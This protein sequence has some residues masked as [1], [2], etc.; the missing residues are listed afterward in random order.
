MATTKFKIRGTIKI[1][2]PASKATNGCNNVA[3]KVK[4]I[5]ISPEPLVR[6]H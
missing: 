2:M 1:M 5:A 6:L 4:V 3:L